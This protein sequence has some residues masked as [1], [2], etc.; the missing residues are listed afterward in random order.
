MFIRLLFSLLA[1]T[2]VLYSVES[3][4]FWAESISDQDPVYQQ[5]SLN[6][7]QER[8]QGCFGSG[9]NE[10]GLRRSS[11]TCAQCDEANG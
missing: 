3:F 8:K 5:D 7:A 10:R 6:P 2:N 11:F 4:D 9:T 1:E